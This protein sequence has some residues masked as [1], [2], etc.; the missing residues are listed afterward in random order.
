MCNLFVREDVNSFDAQNNIIYM[1]DMNLYPMKFTPILKDK[2]WGGNK[3]KQLYRHSQSDSNTIGES[4]DVSD[5]EGDESEVENGFLAENTLSD[6]LAIYMGDLVG[7]KIYEK[8]GNLFPLLI[9]LID[10]DK[11]LS[12]QV[13]PN[14]S[15][16]QNLH[17]EYANGKNEMWYIL[18]AEEGAYLITG[19]R[20]PIT[21]EEY[22]AR[23]EDGTIENVLEKIYVKK[24]DAFYIPAGCVHSIGPGCLVLE[25]Q[26]T[27]DLTYR[28]YDFNRLDENGQ[29]R[30][31]HT[32]WALK[33]IDFENWKNQPIKYHIKPNEMVRLVENDEF[34]LNLM[35]ITKPQEYEIA[36]IDS[37]VILV[38]L[39]GH[40]TCQF[41]DDYQTL[42]E[43]ESILIPAEM[44]SL[45]L[46]PTVDSKLIEVYA[47]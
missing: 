35:Q 28:I 10:A 21:P 2:L 15:L 26:Q 9:K 4:W 23:I 19:F 13:H 6:L 38:C 36:I 44:T 24:G 43:G 40:V 33:A 16:A 12:I 45:F 18:E 5:I 37:F 11:Q 25:V 1:Q 29:L 22:S 39:E 46:V 8:Y 30:E 7:D 17:G 27:S 42:V 20:C 3:I 47:K 41:G 31:L 34:V 14:D 32:D